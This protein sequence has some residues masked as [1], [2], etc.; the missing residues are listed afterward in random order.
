MKPLRPVKA[1]G[2][3]RLYDGLK[4]DPRDPR[5][6]AG[7]RIAA[8]YRQTRLLLDWVSDHLWWSG[9][10]GLA[11]IVW[12]VLS[13]CMV[14]PGFFPVFGAFFLFSGPALAILFTFRRFGRFVPG[15][16]GGI[17][18]LQLYCASILL[19][20]FLALPIMWTQ[21][22]YL[23]GRQKSFGTWTTTVKPRF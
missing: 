9:G 5:P 14:L 12:L 1:Y 2:N 18:L 23:L 19:G 15:G 13:F 8:R 3:R 20:W 4:S 6:R 10:Y 22:L 17:V 7:R 21:L 16:V 11:P